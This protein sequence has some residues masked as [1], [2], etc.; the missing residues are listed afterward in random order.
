M[1][2]LVD[3]NL[4]PRLASFLSNEGHD[5]LFVP[6]SEYRGQPDRVLHDVATAEERI[7]ITRDVRFPVTTELPG[8]ILV[9]AG[10]QTP[11]QLLAMMQEFF[12]GMTEEGLTGQITVVA[13]GRE[14]RS[15]PIPNA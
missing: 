13:P 14:P 6:T 4:S 9:R 1:R 11:S 10:N 8:F 3:E 5:V 2:F 12:S 7:V 15:R